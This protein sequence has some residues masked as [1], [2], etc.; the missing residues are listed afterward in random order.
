M[1]GEDYLLQYIEQRI[2]EE[3]RQKQYQYYVT[4]SLRL[5]SENT[6]HFG[7]GKYM[8][9]RFADMIE[10]RADEPQRTS[11]EIKQSVFD[12]LK[13]IRKENES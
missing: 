6:A 4:D 11:E 7:Q 1:F 3:N 13:S 2:E 10:K 8:S 9:I 5:I 12:T